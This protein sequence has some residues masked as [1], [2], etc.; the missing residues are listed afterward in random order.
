MAPTQGSCSLWLGACLRHLCATWR[1]HPI[2]EGD[3]S[4]GGDPGDSGDGGDPNPRPKRRARTDAPAG[5]PA[6]AQAVE[7]PAGAD[8]FA[9]AGAAA[10]SSSSKSS[11][12]SSTSSSS[13][14]SSGTMASSSVGGDASEADE[15][16]QINGQRV[17]IEM[18][19]GVKGFRV[20]CNN[21]EHRLRGC[22]KWRAEG[23]DLEFG[24]DGWKSYLAC[25]HSV[26]STLSVEEH[27]KTKQPS[28]GDMLAFL[29]P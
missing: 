20:A 12:S 18:N 2:E 7:A 13:S 11:S 8:V 27:R 21:D 19:K 10:G 22:R 23:K 4:V 6:E 24:E 14:S 26:A 15:E 5:A 9:G 1:P 17:C 29:T 16:L 3:S 28:Q 25:W